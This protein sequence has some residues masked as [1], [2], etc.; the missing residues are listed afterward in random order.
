MEKPLLLGAI[1]AGGTELVGVQVNTCAGFKVSLSVE[2]RLK[3]QQI[4]PVAIQSG[5]GRI[6]F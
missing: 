1:R 6:G 3:V 5:R 2:H 4:V